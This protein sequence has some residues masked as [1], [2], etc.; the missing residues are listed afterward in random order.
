LQK[1]LKIYMD[2]TLYTST[3]A[4]LLFSIVAVYSLSIFPTIY[5]GA[6]EFHFL[7]KQSIFVFISIVILTFVGSMNPYRVFKPMGFSIFILSALAIFVML[8]LPDSL[9]REVLGAKRWIKFGSLSIA[10]TEFFKFGFLFFVSWSLARKH[11]ELVSK[12]SLVNEFTLL[13]PYF[14][15]LGVVV[16]FIA[17][18]QKDLGETVV[19]TVTLLAVI[20]LA[21]GSKKLF[22]TLISGAIALVVLLIAIAPHRL[23]RLKGWWVGVQDGIL[24]ILPDSFETLRVTDTTVALPIVNAISAIGSGGIGGKSLGEGQYKLGFLSEVHTDYIFAGVAEEIGLIGV[25]ILLALYGVIL[26]RM[27]YIASYLVKPIERYFVIGVAIIIFVSGVINLFGVTGL[28]PI[29]GIAVPLLSYG[30]SQ[31]IATSLAIAMV[32]MLSRKVKI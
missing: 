21:G 32:L 10:P 23:S 19:I 5:Y 20:L 16:V 30:G 22:F 17:V 9:V 4:I 11:N 7:K 29:K 31:I 13:I 28:I 18:G 6:S 1:R 2:R 26:Y 3:V 8:F 24:A 25:L 27:F 12:N 15:L 14:A